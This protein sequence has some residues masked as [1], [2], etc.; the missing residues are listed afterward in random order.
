MREGAEKQPVS[1]RMGPPESPSSCVTC[2]AL[3]TGRFC[4]A[5]GQPAMDGPHTLRRFG[6]A[7]LHRLFDLDRGF[8]HTVTRLTRNPGEAIREY[9]GGRT[10]VYV[11]PFPYLLIA[12]AV[13]VLTLRVLPG[14]VVGDDRGLVATLVIFMAF[15]GRLV[16]FR[17]GKNL[18]EHLIVAMYLFAHGVLLST[19]VLVLLTWTPTGIA[20]VLMGVWL[21]LLPLYVV[22]GYV[23]VFR[24]RPVRA[25]LQALAVLLLGMVSW[26]AATLALVRLLVNSS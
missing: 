22:C 3:R 16:F 11:H 2:G 17:E 10:I 20:K 13:M 9:L 19:P 26:G 12:L 8:L 23:G 25:A 6:A 14:W 4:A 1:G 24:D 15:T 5:C 21:V 7:V 18:A